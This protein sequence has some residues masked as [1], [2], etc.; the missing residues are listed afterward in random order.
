MKT[1]VLLCATDPCNQIT[2]RKPFICLMQVRGARLSPGYG[3]SID[4]GG[5]RSTWAMQ[6]GVIGMPD[7]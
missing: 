4:S 7:A 1:E 2:I 3:Q 6:V 5:H